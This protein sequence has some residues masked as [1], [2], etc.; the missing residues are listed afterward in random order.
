MLQNFKHR[1]GL[2]RVR[3][4]GDSE[5]TDTEAFGIPGMKENSR[6]ENLKEYAL[7]DI[8]NADK[9]ALSKLSEKSKQNMLDLNTNNS[10]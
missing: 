5:V 1:H 6:R 3:T 10:Q 9:A 8:Y 7:C 4:Q 2:R